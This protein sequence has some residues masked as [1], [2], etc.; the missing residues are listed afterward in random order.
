MPYFFNNHSA[1][2]GA[3]LHSEDSL[4]GDE[5]AYYAETIVIDIEALPAYTEIIVFIVNAFTGGSFSCV[6]SACTD[7]NKILTDGSISTI[8][9]IS[10]GCGTNS[11]GCIASLLY[12]NHKSRRSWML[13]RIGHFCDGRNFVECLPAIRTHVD[14]LMDPALRSER[15]LSPDKTLNMTKGGAVEIPSSLLQGSY[16]IRIGMAGDGP[17]AAS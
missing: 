15:Q 10:T 17:L 9:S 4:K 2:S 13:R 6:E 1:A 3:L 11:T 14:K 12:R 8:S 5:S 16:D 7:L